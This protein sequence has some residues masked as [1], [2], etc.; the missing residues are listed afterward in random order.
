VKI[1]K[2]IDDIMDKN[3]V[4]FFDSVL[5]EAYNSKSPVTDDMLKLAKK[6][7]PKNKDFNRF[8]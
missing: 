7:F 4:I 5:V 6:A 8:K 2:K 3:Y 1:E